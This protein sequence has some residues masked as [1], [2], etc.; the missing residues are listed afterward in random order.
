MKKINNPINMIFFLPY[1]SERTPNGICINAFVN[2]Y[3][4]RVTP[5][6]KGVEKKYES[7]KTESTGKTINA[8]NILKK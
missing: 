7:A 2:P 4:P 5:I 8:P 6:K 3:I 1:L